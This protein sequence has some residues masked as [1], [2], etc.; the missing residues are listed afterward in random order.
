MCILM[1]VHT[2]I[3]IHMYV[4]IVY[5]CMHVCSIQCTRTH[6]YMLIVCM[7]IVFLYDT[8]KYVMMYIRTYVHMCWFVLP[9]DWCALIK[10][11][12]TYCG[13]RYCQAVQSRNGGKISFCVWCIDYVRLC[14]KFGSLS[15]KNSF[16]ILTVQSSPWRKWV[17]QM[18]CTINLKW[19]ALSHHINYTASDSATNSTHTWAALRHV[20]E[21]FKWFMNCICC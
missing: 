7:C 11:W 8:R 1:H 6:M 19:A 13:A 21:F 14:N 16:V 3:Y 4:C 18:I 12:W 15:G 5:L 2:C 9:G 10:S 17:L 20:S